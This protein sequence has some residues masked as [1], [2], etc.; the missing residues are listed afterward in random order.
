MT[1]PAKCETCERR[2]VTVEMLARAVH[3]GCALT[4]RKHTYDDCPHKSN[5]LTDARMLW[6]HM[7]KQSEGPTPSP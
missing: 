2:L 4:G 1:Q 7:D 3:S 6:K 5:F